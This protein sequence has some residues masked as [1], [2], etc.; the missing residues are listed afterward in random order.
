MQGDLNRLSKAQ[1]WEIRSADQQKVS[2]GLILQIL[3]ISFNVKQYRQNPDNFKTLVFTLSD[4]V[5]SANCILVQNAKKVLDNLTPKPFDVIQANVLYT[6]RNLVILD[7]KILREGQ[8]G[9][10][11]N[12]VDLESYD[13]DG[14]RR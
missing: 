12:P 10:I 7:W 1:L 13:N 8:N 11:G 6:K 9:N 3:E 5:Y 4:G 2:F 14:I